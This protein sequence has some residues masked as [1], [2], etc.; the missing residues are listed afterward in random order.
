MAAYL[1]GL[2]KFNSGNQTARKK[3]RLI[4]CDVVRIEQQKSINKSI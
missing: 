1:S 4:C 2:T 3:W